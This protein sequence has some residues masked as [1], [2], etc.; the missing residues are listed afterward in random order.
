[1]G[2]DSSSAAERA[3]YDAFVKRDID[4]MRRVWRG[5]DDI[6]CVHPGGGLLL[7]S[8][9]VMGSW[10]DIFTGASPPDMQVRPLQRHVDGDTAM[11][12]VEE[13]IANPA[14]QRSARVIATNVYRRT[15]DGWLLHLHHASLPLV[16]TTARHAAA[17]PAL[18]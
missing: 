18:H 13:Q 4:A 7:G 12:L 11:H 8:T 2:F 10:A 15:P 1:M 9:E 5:T 17:R 6:A 16:E 3:F 14:Q